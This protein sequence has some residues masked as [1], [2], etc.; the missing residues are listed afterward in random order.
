MSLEFV[1]PFTKKFMTFRAPLPDDMWGTADK[2]LRAAGTP[3]QRHEFKELQDIRSAF[4]DERPHKVGGR[5][6]P[7]FARSSKRGRGGRGGMGAREAYDAVVETEM[8]EQI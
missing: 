4:P 6:A 5:G 3:D 8:F 7:R 2:I 1:H